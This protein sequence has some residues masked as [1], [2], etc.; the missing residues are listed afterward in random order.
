[1]IWRFLYS[2]LHGVS[3]GLPLLLTGSTFQAWLKDSN[4]DLGYIGLVSLIGLPYTLKFVWAPI[5]DRF[6]FKK[7][8][9]RKGWIFLFQLCL[10]G[11]LSLM[12]TS[13]PA[14]SPYFLV[15]AAFLTSFFSASQDIVIDAYRREVLPDKEL[16]MGSSL[17][18]NGYRIAI[19]LSGA[20]ALFLADIMPWNRVYFIMAIIM[21][22]SAFINLFAPLEDP[23]QETPRSIKDAVVHP[24]LDFFK[25]E[26]AITIL[27][28][29][30][31]YKV[32]DSMADNMKVPFILDIGFTKT[33]LATIVKTFGLAATISGGL[34]G[35]FL[36]IRWGI[37]RSLFIFGLLQM[38]STA[39][40]SVQAIVGPSKLCLI[41]VIAFE[42]LSMG[43][44]TAAFA[45]YMA[46]LT[47]KKFTGT[48]F[49]LLTSFMGVPRVIASA[50]TGYMVEAMGWVSFFIFCTLIALPG[51][52]I[53]LKYLKPEER[54]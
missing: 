23:S 2:F 47:N 3:S 42:N 51:L 34:I 48:Q 27:L 29:I 11:T 15:I 28:F 20:F 6:H 21:G 49:A 9:R 12:A 24:F 43:M 44:G 31:F 37:Y 45:A 8:G 5:L 10:V 32:G 1:M 52:F 30:L 17:Y 13:N 36:I 39:G 40:F 53:L 22:V 46:T 4:V 50:P 33:E 54:I 19:L 35:G 26:G 14:D 41:G 25:K 38:I 16:G 18:V 7:F